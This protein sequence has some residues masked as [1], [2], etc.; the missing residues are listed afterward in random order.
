MKYEVPNMQ[1]IGTN[2]QIR[3][4]QFM[5]NKPKIPEMCTGIYMQIYVLY[6]LLYACICTRINMP[7]YAN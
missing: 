7:L 5:H 6:A 4:M 1:E 2:M 3:N